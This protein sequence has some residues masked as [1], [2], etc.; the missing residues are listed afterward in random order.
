MGD[1]AQPSADAM[2]VDAQQ[3]NALS[4]AT[5]I[6]RLCALIGCYGTPTFL[7]TDNA[8]TFTS[9]WFRLSLWLLN[10]RRNDRLD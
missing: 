5:I 9:R 7:R 4:A 8:A 10:T 6:V 3:W 2:T 1:F